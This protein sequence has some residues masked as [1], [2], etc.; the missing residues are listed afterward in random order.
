MSG[1]N[2]SYTLDQIEE[3]AV[4]VRDRFD[5]PSSNFIDI[6]ELADELGYE[7]YDAEFEDGEVVSTLC[8]ED[9]DGER[10]VYVDKSLSE[11]EKRFN[12]ANQ[13]AHIILNHHAN[14][15][16]H[17]FLV[18]YRPRYRGLSDADQY[19]EK[20][21]AIL[22]AAALLMPREL[23]ENGWKKSRNLEVIAQYF[24]VPA[25]LAMV[26]LDAMGLI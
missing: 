5:I 23:V 16:P 18:E 11:P 14:L 12:I 22:L 2:Q 6:T 20:M 9:D 4:K 17:E 19:G 7:V 26:R 24:K 25:S 8:L 3:L 13:V 15:K 1:S 21:Q 10:C